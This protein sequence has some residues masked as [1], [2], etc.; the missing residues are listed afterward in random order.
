MT[1]EID[2]FNEERKDD[3]EIRNYTGHVANTSSTT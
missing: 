3:V 2:K 1:G